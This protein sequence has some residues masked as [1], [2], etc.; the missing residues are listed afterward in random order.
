MTF[1]KRRLAAWN[2]L[3]SEQPLSAPKPKKAPRT[4]NTSPTEFEEQCAYV[5]WLKANNILFFAIPNA[6][7][8]TLY[9]QMTNKAQ[10][11]IAGVPDVFVCERPYRITHEEIASLRGLF[12]ELKRIQ[13][14][15]VSEVQ[16]NMQK[17]LRVAGF[18]V[19]VAYGADD[20]IQITKTYLG[21]TD[22]NPTITQEPSDKFD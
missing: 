13:G 6:G 3:H 16:Q 10:G 20:A 19:F 21:M 11:L 8:R 7:R 2:Q 12:V 5:K 15:V 18:A 9:E 1:S 17:R 4:A 22:D 14:G